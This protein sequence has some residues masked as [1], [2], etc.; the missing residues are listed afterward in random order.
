MWKFKPDNKFW[1]SK[2]SRVTAQ[3]HTPLPCDRTQQPCLVQIMRLTLRLVN[4]I[5][6]G[7]DRMWSSTVSVEKSKIQK[8][9]STSLYNRRSVQ[10][11]QRA[12]VSSM[13]TL[14]LC[15]GRRALQSYSKTWTKKTRK[16]TRVTQTICD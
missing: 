15:I 10:A 5:F 4:G 2:Q 9:S 6:I 13:H 3:R 11:K 16:Y 12:V 8:K 7:M 1:P 14:R